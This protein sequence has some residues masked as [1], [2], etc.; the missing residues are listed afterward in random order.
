MKEIDCGDSV[1]GPGE[2]AV[3]H[4]A[5]RLEA[6]VKA[7]GTPFKLILYGHDNRCDCCELEKLPSSHVPSASSIQR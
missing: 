4:E 5:P 2:F 1:A 6:T 7:I 3:Q